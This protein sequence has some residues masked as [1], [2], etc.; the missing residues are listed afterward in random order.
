MASNIKNQP[1]YYLSVVCTHPT[2]PSS[3][4]PVRFGERTGIAM[5]DESA[6]GNATGYTTVYFGPCVAE[7]SVKGID[8][9]GNSA[10]AVGDSIYYVDADTPVLSKK[11]SGYFVGFALGTVGSG[12]T[13]TINVAKVDGGAYSGSVG[14]SDIATG[15]VTAV[16][17]AATLKTGFIP[18]SL[19]MVREVFSNAITNIAANGGI[20]A[21]DTTPILNYT[22]GDT[23][24]ALRMAWAAS[25]ADPIVFQVALPPDLDDAAAV[26][27]HFR[28]AMAGASDTPVI[29]ADTYFNEGDTKVEDD[30]AAV[31]G[32]SYAEYVI[33]VAAADVPSG[34]QTLT[35]ELT[36]GAHGTDILYMTALWVEYTRA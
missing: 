13:A 36:P 21:S 28:A 2:T 34:A 16:K 19:N 35:C 12:Q 22:N 6:G 30:S 7:L 26:E 17:L 33:T 29:S 15:A 18:V 5:T 27:I 3:G 11:A 23:D 24:S 10:V 14:T 4:D 1:G 32:T 8:D 25:N 20:L 9:S 31:T